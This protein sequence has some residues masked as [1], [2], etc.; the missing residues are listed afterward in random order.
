MIVQDNPEQM[1]YELIDG[2]TLLGIADYQRHGDTLVFPHTVI[3]AERRG[4]GL[5]DVLVQGALDSARQR[6]VT[7][8]A[9]CW[10]VEQF[11]ATHPEY[12]DLVATAATDGS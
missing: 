8:E 4:E 10:F 11:V 12:A 6:G 9:R 7:I 5:G 3:V 1:R 2:E